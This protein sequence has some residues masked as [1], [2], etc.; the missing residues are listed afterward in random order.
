K[1]KTIR[2]YFKDNDLNRVEV[3]GNGESLFYPE[4][5]SSHIGLNNAV[6]SEIIMVFQD[7]KIT[8]VKFLYDPNSKLTPLKQITSEER[9]LECF[10][11]HGLLR[12]K[13]RKD[14]FEWK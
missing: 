13:N 11:W 14:V 10:I 1:G 6:S 7:G 4:E 8:G 2:G 9:K 12:P 3:I 5:D